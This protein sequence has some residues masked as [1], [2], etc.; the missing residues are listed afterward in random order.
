MTTKETGN[1]YEAQAVIYLKQRDWLILDRNYNFHHKEIDIIAQ[2]DDEICFIEVKYRKSDEFGHP[3]Q[4]VTTQK[5]RNIKYAA[6][7]YVMEKN[8]VDKNFTFG[9]ISIIR[10]KI[11]FKRG[12]FQW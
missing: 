8:I 12:F 4:F 6:K 7:G 10:G 2:K 3:E 5:K 11:F 9:I 1:K